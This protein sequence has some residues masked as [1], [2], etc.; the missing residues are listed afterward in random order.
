MIA[1]SRPAAVFEV[2]KELKVSPKFARKLV[3]ESS[4]EWLTANA[5]AASPER[6]A[7][8]LEDELSY[9]IDNDLIP[10]VEFA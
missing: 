6:F 3:L 2:A 5:F 7:S 1:T 8:A 4:N 9:F 10:T